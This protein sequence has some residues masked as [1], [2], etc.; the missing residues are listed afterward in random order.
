MN[1]W[2]YHAQTANIRLNTRLVGD[3]AEIAQALDIVARLFKGTLSAATLIG[4]RGA[5]S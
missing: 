5:R 1:G 4:R 2:A 3:P